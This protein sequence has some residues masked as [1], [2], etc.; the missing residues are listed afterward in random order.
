M[1]LEGPIKENNDELIYEP[2]ETIRGK[3]KKTKFRM[4]SPS[5]TNLMQPWLKIMTSLKTV[6]YTS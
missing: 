3:K 4:N 5:A 2:I 6:S 1:L